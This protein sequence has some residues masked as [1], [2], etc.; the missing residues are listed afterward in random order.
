[1][2]ATSLLEKQHRKVESIFKQL[3]S[4]R[5]EPGPLLAELANELV[6]HMAIEQESFYPAVR[7]IKEDLILESYEEHAI[8]ELALKR[9]L[10]TDPEDISFKARV[11]TLK[12]L[13]QHHVEEEEEELFPK[14]EEAIEAKQL[15]QLGK[16]LKAEFE[17]RL[18][19]GY[20]AL[21]PAGYKK[22]SADKASHAK[23]AN[24]AN[25]G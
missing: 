20:E 3:E 21:L 5:S 8:A 9:L 12:E 15:E 2:K 11:T 13:I 17:Q 19:E 7:Q 25:L 6:A 4:G 24:G 1:M 14:V 22:T 18:A 10:S 23:H 16:A